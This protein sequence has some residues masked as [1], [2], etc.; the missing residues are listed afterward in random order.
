M[1]HHINLC[2]ASAGDRAKRF[3]IDLS[4]NLITAIMSLSSMPDRDSKTMV[5]LLE[6]QVV[7]LTSV[8]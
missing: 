8:S 4:V 2:W 5:T 1:P 3:F 7:T 6:G